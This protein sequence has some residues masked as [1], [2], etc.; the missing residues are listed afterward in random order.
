MVLEIVKSF[1]LEPVSFKKH[2]SYFLCNTK[3]KTYVLKKVDYGYKDIILANNIKSFLV[4]NNF[5]NIDVFYKN[6]KNMPYQT[7]NENNY[8]LTDLIEDEC[9]NYN[10]E[11]IFLEFIQTL[12]KMNNK[13]KKTYL[14]SKSSECLILNYSNSLKRIVQIKKYIHKQSKISEFDVLFL[15]KNNEYIEEIQNTIEFLQNTTYEK[16]KK[17]AIENKSISHNN[18]K[19]EFI[20]HSQNKIYI[21]SFFET[22]NNYHFTDLVSA[23]LSYVDNCKNPISISKILDI[24]IKHNN[25]ENEEIK[26]I[27][28]MLNYPYKF[29]KICN[30]F[31]SKKMN[32]VPNYILNKFQKTIERKEFLKNYIK[33]IE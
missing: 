29:I 2:K 31:Y 14:T 18:L 16:H 11:K 7:Y 25:L 8:I 15:K 28:A 27:Y 32:Y 12:S 33:K 13:L 1:N 23:I 5:E 22:T 30:K 26:I 24:Y 10:N 9:I 3:N 21:T 4:K 20:I 17:I 19:K 6:Y